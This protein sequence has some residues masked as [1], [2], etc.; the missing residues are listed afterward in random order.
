MSF[1]CCAVPPCQS[2]RTADTSPRTQ[3]KYPDSLRP[4][5]SVMRAFCRDYS[6]IKTV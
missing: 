1:P 4:S 2:E 3:H 6:N 5:E